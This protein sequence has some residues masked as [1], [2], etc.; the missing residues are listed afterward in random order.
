MTL[1]ILEDAAEDL[2]S[3]AQFVGVGDYFRD[4]ILSSISLKD[5]VVAQI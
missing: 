1:E 5:T 4:S 2:E 3:G